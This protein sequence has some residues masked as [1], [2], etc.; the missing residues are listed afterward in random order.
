MLS[1]YRPGDFAYIVENNRRIRE[2]EIIK[3]SGGFAT[4]RF[5]NVPGGI[6]LR[7]NRLFSTKEEAEASLPEK[8][9]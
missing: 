4:I 3:I 2:V 5:V 9:L 1:E 7:L 8:P 6:N